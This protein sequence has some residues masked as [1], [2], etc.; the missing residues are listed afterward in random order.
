MKKYYEEFISGADSRVP[1]NGGYLLVYLADELLSIVSIP[2]PE[3]MADNN[4][5]SIV[6]NDDTFEDKSGNQYD[7]E[8]R[9]SKYGI[10]WYLVSYPD[11]DEI[12]QKLRYEVRLNE[13]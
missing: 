1:L 13:Y 8:I 3:Y 4:R 10:D 6:E 5:D 2:A 9:S 7:I 11:D 12:I